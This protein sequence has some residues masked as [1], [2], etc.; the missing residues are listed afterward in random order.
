MAQVVQDYTI[1]ES[2]LDQLREAARN[3]IRTGRPPRIAETRDPTRTHELEQY[4]GFLLLEIIIQIGTLIFTNAGCAL[5]ALLQLKGFLYYVGLQIKTTSGQTLKDRRPCWEFG[6]V[7]DSK[8]DGCIMVFRSIKD[9]MMWIIPYREYLTHYS[10]KVLYIYDSTQEMK[11]WGQYRVTMNNIVPVLTK[12]FLVANENNLVS[13]KDYTIAMTPTSDIDRKRYILR[14]RFE[15]ILHFER[16][17]LVNLTYSMVWQNLKI[18]E[19]LAS[20]GSNLGYVAQ[21]ERGDHAK[22]TRADLDILLVHVNHPYDKYFYFIPA[23]VLGGRGI[24]KSPTCRGK[25]CFLVYPPGSED[26]RGKG[27][28]EPDRWAKDFIHEY[29]ESN[30]EA[31]LIILCKGWG[32]LK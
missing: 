8:Y 11:I 4:T 10:S 9:Q 6:H 24:L 21:C 22:C 12:Y 7:I 19:T 29:Q 16:P 18:K 2:P 3:E 23:D 14:Q 31:N 15:G 30:L 27:G 28:R 5:D 20:K 1:Y 32:L 13:T 26:A 17:I 25:Q